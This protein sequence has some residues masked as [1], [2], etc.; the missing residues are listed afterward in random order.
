MAATLSSDF[1]FEPKVWKDHIMAYFDRKMIYG[2]LALRDDTLTREPGETV[3]FPY[4]KQIGPAEEPAEDEGLNVDNLSDDSFS[5]T[6]KEVGKAVGIKKKA[7]KKSAASEERN[8][9]EIQR[10]LA[11]VHA[12]K[13]DQDLLTEISLASSHQAVAAT[14]AADTMSIRR[15]WRGKVEGFGDKHEQAIAIQMHSL[16]LLDLMTDTTTGFLKADATD[17]MFGQAGFEGRLAGMAVFVSDTI[18]QGPQVGGKDT[19]YAFLHKLDAYGLLMKQDM[20]LE[21][22]KDILAREWV[23]TSNQWYAVKSFHAKI[24][25]LD[26]KTVRLQTTIS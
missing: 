19:Y 18:P 22:D 20:E 4:F 3:N 24:N 25:A 7:F 17:P 8:V 11:R 16:Q 15:V 10:Q 14:V 26:K 21:S 2:A 12:E 9:S 6:V 1:V 13:I 23:F 5:S